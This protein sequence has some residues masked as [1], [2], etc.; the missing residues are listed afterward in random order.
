M[1]WNLN[2]IINDQSHD[3]RFCSTF[4]IIAWWCV[5]HTRA[6][7][8]NVTYISLYC[9]YGMAFVCNYF[10]CFCC[11]HHH[12]DHLLDI[13]YKSNNQG[14][15]KKKL[16]SQIKI[17]SIFYLLCIIILYRNTCFTYTYL[18]YTSLDVRNKEICSR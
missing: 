8:H 3:T 9:W 1:R 12:F 7:V 16:S 5:L 15:R 13:N 14:V 17:Q 11:I 10:V 2:E 4:W 6:D 18:Y